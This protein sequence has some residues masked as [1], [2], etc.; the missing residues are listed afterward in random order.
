MIG[1][2]IWAGRGV[3]MPWDGSSIPPMP[4]IGL[5]DL[6]GLS[7]LHPSWVIHWACHFRSEHHCPVMRLTDPISS[8][9]GKGKGG[10]FSHSSGS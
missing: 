1:T 9:V 3:Y 7:L 5:L 2:H 4:S 8:S 6:L 10:D